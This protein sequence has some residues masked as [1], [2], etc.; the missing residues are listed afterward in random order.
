MLP[1]KS[2]FWWVGRKWFACFW[3]QGLVLCP[4]RPP[5]PELILKVS[6]RMDLLK[7]RHASIH[8]ACVQSFLLPLPTSLLDYMNN[9]LSS[10]MLFPP[11]RI[12]FS[13]WGTWET[14]FIFQ[15]SVYILCLLCSL[16]FSVVITCSFLLPLHFCMPDCC[17]R[18]TVL[19]LCCLH[20]SVFSWTTFLG[21]R[22]YR[23]S[24][25]GVAL[26]CCLLRS[27]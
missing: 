2:L 15:T 20:I 22:Y 8:D 25:I 19:W 6:F 4:L 7:C 23:F 9:S 11:P 10:F 14:H 5:T 27:S 18:Y 17:T 16:L 26:A 13:L 1:L 3:Q 24:S 12:P 21:A